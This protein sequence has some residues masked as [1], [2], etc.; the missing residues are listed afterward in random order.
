MWGPSLHMASQEG[1]W[2]EEEETGSVPFGIPKET[3]SFLWD[4]QRNGNFLW[5]S[6]RNCR[7]FFRIPKSN[8]SF[9]WDP[10]RNRYFS[11]GFPEAM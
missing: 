9:P 8:A 2:A 10:Q 1:V 4:T 6:Q 7:V 5:D 11:L 3:G